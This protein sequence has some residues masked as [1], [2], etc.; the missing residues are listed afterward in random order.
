MVDLARAREKSSLLASIISQRD[1]ESISELI[2]NYSR[3]LVFSSL[4]DL[5]ISVSAWRYVTDLH[6]TPRMVFA[7]PVLLQDHP[8][9][10]LYYRVIAL[11]SQ[12]QVGQLASSVSGWEDASRLRELSDCGC[13]T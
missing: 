2:Q 10:S 3:E 8:N 9:A 12:K 7:H 6:I 1:D 4:D 5:M 13:R 11:L